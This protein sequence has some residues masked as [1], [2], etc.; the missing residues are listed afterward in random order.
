MLVKRG[1]PAAPGVAIAPALV[2]GLKD[3]R[4]PNQFTKVD[5]VESEI[6]RL[7]LA[8]DHV[9]KELEEQQ[10]LVTERLGAQFGAIFEAHLMMARDP[11][12]I[13]DIEAK[14]R[15]RQY[16][17]EFAASTVLR[18]HAKKLREL[19]SAYLSERASDIFDLEKNL[20]RHL[21]DALHQ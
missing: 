15:R 11:K 21:L 6:V 3:F 14:I 9:C 2:F 10:Q 16:S 13:A 7:H 4:I 17:P 20:L 8:L 19:G 1:I 5:A 18:R 12:L